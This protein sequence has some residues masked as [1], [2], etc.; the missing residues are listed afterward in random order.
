MIENQHL[1]DYSISEERFNRYTHALALLA[2]VAGFICLLFAAIQTADPYRIISSLIFG[3]CLC[4]FY[5]V[6][7][8]YHSVRSDRLRYLFRRLDHIGIYSLIAGTYTPI[9][10][11]T[12]REG[13][14]WILFALVWLLAVGG[15]IYKIFWVHTIPFLAPVL[16]I[17]LG[18]L[19]VVDLEQ[20]LQRMPPAGVAWLVGGGIVY[21]VGVLFYA[22]EKI[23]YN[24]GIWHLFVIGGS[25]CHYLTILWY[26]IPLSPS[27]G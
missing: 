4:F 25:L 6:S 20:F 11:V 14:G 24:H 2:A 27:T 9:T 7:T 8:L 3:S 19:I 17:A 18:W 1:I 10:L 16:Y 23:P 12:L 21:T 22:I 5:V 26:V 13:N 15:I